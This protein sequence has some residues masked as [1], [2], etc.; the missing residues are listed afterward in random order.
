MMN[1]SELKTKGSAILVAVFLGL[2]IALSKGFIGLYEFQGALAGLVGV[3][4]LIA[5]ATLGESPIAVTRSLLNQGVLGKTRIL[6]F[7]GLVLAV[8]S[9]VSLLTPVLPTQVAFVGIGTGVLAVV[10]FLFA[11]VVEEYNG[12]PTIITRRQRR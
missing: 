2:F 3:R 7:L 11:H 10:A 5:V 12:V 8:V 9:Q 4:L 6:A 1:V